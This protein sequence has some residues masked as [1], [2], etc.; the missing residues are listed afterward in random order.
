VSK[1]PVEW[2]EDCSPA[3]LR[4]LRR[5]DWRVLLPTPTG[6]FQHLVL[7]GGPPGLSD[8]IVEIGLAR[9]VS[10]EIPAER[11]ADAVAILGD[12]GVGCE[13]VAGCLAPG[14]VLYWEVESPRIPAFWLRKKIDGRLR[15]NG[16]SPTAVY[17]VRPNFER[18]QVFLPLDSPT[19][20]EW[21]LR[22]RTDS[23][24]S[25]HRLLTSRV[26]SITA[27]ASMNVRRTRCCAVTAV[28]GDAQG[29]FPSILADPAVPHE[30]QSAQARL[31]VVNRGGRDESRRVIVFPFHPSS[32]NPAA[33]LKF[34][35]LLERND[36]VEQEQRIA[37]QIRADLD[38]GLRASI[39]APLGS[40][41]WGRTVVGVETCAR[42]KPM[43][44][45][46][47]T[48]ERIDDLRAATDWLIRFHGQT[49]V[50]RDPLSESLIGTWIEQP[51][52]EFGTAFGSTAEEAALF[53][54]VRER[55]QSLRGRP[56]PLVRYFVPL[57]E[58]HICRSG[59]DITVT[60]WEGARIGPPLLALLYFVTLWHQRSRHDRGQPTSVSIADLDLRHSDG[61][62]AAAAS[63]MLD[64][65]MKR[66]SI[67]PGF[68]PVMLVLT[69]VIRALGRLRRREAFGETEIDART[70]NR[71][72]ASVGILAEHAD[73]LFL[74]RT[75]EMAGRS[76][77]SARLTTLVLWALLD[78]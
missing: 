41:V 23:R 18:C 63:E 28:A 66:L 45:H 50:S 46:A 65:Y 11:S 75:A 67:D 32:A 74:E 27:K 4:S 35:R 56:F 19:A 61:D 39:P 2:P 57:S 17:W 51:L 21:Y 38:P 8:V 26:G 48:R 68:L 20:M 58:L 25:L 6:G 10:R 16:L 69:W 40:F 37:A 64:E 77:F 13:E 7:L 3:G 34:S 71:H 29:V 55:A 47:P 43:S 72:E 59:R 30:W 73:L 44:R 36:E 33:V 9:C 12:A 15:S 22:F 49:Q 78:C 70:G 53:A 76:R 5:A 52:E 42:G 31:L 24:S 54:R 62:L 1:N 14:G 60:D